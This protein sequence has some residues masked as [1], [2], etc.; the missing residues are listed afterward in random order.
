MDKPKG[1]RLGE[2]TEENL[3]AVLKLKTAK[4]QE[5]FVAP[6]SVSLA[7]AHFNKSAWYRAIYHDD[8]VVGFVMLSIDHHKPE[9]YLW[10]Y[11]IDEKH[12]GEG[13]G[14]KALRLIIEYI[15]QFPQ[16]HKLLLSYSP[17]N[18]NPSDFYKKLGFVETDEWD[19]DERI[20]KLDLHT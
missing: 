18:G 14:L 16:A 15:K 7:Q 4:A 1:I 11:M 6:N 17:G 20:M 8:N 3:V 2:V 10:R 19:E 5:E 12:Q 13:Y 9:Y